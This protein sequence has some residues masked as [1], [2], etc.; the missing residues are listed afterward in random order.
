V[1][2]LSCLVIC[3]VLW[4]GLPCDP[5]ALSSDCFVLSYRCHAFSCPIQSNLVLSILSCFVMDSS[6]P[7]IKYASA[8]YLDELPTTGSAGGLVLSCLLL[9]V[10][11]SPCVVP[12][13]IVETLTPYFLLFTLTLTLTCPL[14]RLMMNDVLWCHVGRAFRDLDVEQEVIKLSYYLRFCWPR[15]GRVLL[16][17]FS[18]VLCL[19]S[20]L[21]FS[22]SY[23]VL[24]SCFPPLAS[25]LLLLVVVFVVVFVVIFVLVLKVCLYLILSPLSSSVPFSSLLLP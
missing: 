8:K 13:V 23:L 21:V 14:S 6:T 16:S 7:P 5:L 25:C 2:G 9:C 15:L 10:F 11:L 4:R 3:P 22:W 18:L 1:F 17:C 20:S 24:A 12:C 19:L